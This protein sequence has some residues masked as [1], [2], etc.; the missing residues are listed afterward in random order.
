M[1]VNYTSPAVLGDAFA[2]GVGMAQN[3][4]NMAIRREEAIRL[5]AKYEDDMQFIPLDKIAQGIPNDMQQGMMQIAESGGYVTEINGVKGA[6]KHKLGEFMKDFSSNKV[7]QATA[8]DSSINLIN[9]GME[10]G[11]AQVNQLQGVVQKDL[12][13]WQWEIQQLHKKANAEG[14]P[15]SMEAVYKYEDKIKKYQ[16]ENPAFAQLQEITKQ[17]Q[18]LVELRS[19]RLTAAGKIN[20]TYEKDVEQFGKETAFQI[21]IGKADRRQLM[22]QQKREEANIA[23]DAQVRA[24]AAKKGMGGDGSEKNEIEKDK[25]LVKAYDNVMLAPNNRRSGQANANY[26]NKHSKQDRL[27][28]KDKEWVLE[29]IGAG[30]NPEP[31]FKRYLK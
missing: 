6:Y 5:R 21:A 7:W 1:Q 12:A 15:V 10:E 26:Y 3:E 4:E 25:S 18:Q 11:T 8:L 30:Q 13:A 22:L 19:Q 31:K 20:D 24:Y 9:K 2:K 16:A 23:A 14:K 29:P 28:W 17:M 27:V